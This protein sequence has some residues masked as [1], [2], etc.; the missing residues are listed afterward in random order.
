MEGLVLGLG[1]LKQN[2]NRGHDNDKVKDL[3]LISQIRHFCV[4]AQEMIEFLTPDDVCYKPRVLA[5]VSD[6]YEK[7]YSDVIPDDF[8][9]V[10][11]KP[12]VGA[13]MKKPT[14]PLSICG[15]KGGGIVTMICNLIMWSSF[16][17]ECKAVIIE[18]LESR[19]Q[20]AVAN[21]EHCHGKKEI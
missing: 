20:Q 21:T 3:N 6:A 17:Q 15:M 8:W 5:W 19:E 2:S 13:K 14:P 16:N 12:G 4:K 1:P 18:C 11:L 10:V 9:Q 7:I